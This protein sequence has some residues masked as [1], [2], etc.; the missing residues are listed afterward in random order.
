M[1]EQVAAK[2]F[3]QLVPTFEVL[4]YE[5]AKAW[6]TKCKQD[7]ATMKEPGC[8]FYDFTVTQDQK[9]II[10]R[11][12]YVTPDDLKEHLKNVGPS[13]TEQLTT[14][15]SLKLLTLEVH[16]P[17]SM[18]A[19]CRAACKGLPAKFFVAR[20]KTG[21]CGSLA[22]RGNLRNREAA[23]DLT[24]PTSFVQLCPMFEVLNQDGADAFMDECQTHMNS[25]EKGCL[26]YDF[27]EEQDGGKRMLC[28][29]AYADAAALKEHLGNVGKSL[30]AVLNETKALKILSLQVHCPKEMLAE[31][32]EYVDAFKPDYFVAYDVPAGDVGGLAGRKELTYRE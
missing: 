31:C 27:T 21:D 8:L 1:A 7:M 9:N 2:S 20:C 32:K 14:E 23:T 22:K 29:E 10:C 24:V 30:G 4:N 15:K 5:V 16:C 17:K 12:A 19:E 18:L 3:I 25:N 11:E 26:F 6:M 13:L 28:R